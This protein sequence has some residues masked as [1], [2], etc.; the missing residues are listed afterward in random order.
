MSVKC[1]D[2]YFLN[3]LNSTYKYKELRES[4]TMESIQKDNYFLLPL[5]A[6]LQP[7]YML[8]PHFHS[9]FLPQMFSQGDFAAAV[10]H[11]A[12]HMLCVEEQ[13]AV[14]LPRRNK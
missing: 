14:S 8:A 13:S 2:F 4:V 3:K 9:V 5:Q 6:T 10:L 7:T 1:D 12:F 11:F